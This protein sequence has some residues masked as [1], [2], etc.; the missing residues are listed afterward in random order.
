MR[1]GNDPDLIVRLPDGLHAAVAM[2]AT[3]YA[4]SADIEPPFGPLPL[5]DFEGLCQ[6]VQLIDRLRQ[7]GRYPGANNDEPCSPT[8]S[9]YD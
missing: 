9:G 4:R 2:S 8:G 5:L 3:D 7:E 1:R 6:I